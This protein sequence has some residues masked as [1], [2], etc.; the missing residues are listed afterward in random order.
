[1]ACPAVL[2]C[3]GVSKGRPK[4]KIQRATTLDVSCSRQPLQ[5]PKNAKQKT[6][7]SE[8]KVS[9]NRKQQ[10]KDSLREKQLANILPQES[11]FCFCFGVLVFVNC[12]RFSCVSELAKQQLQSSLLQVS[13]SNCLTSYFIIL[14]YQEPQKPMKTSYLQKHD[15]FSQKTTRCFRFQQIT[16]HPLNK[17]LRISHCPLPFGAHNEISFAL[18]T[19]HLQ[20]QSQRRR[21]GT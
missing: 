2:A 11:G 4:N 5:N 19:R 7:L 10:K 1:M 14:L 8:G 9:G 21:P 16:H 12:F 18:T 3:S 20:L 13:S 6:R 15:A 17:A